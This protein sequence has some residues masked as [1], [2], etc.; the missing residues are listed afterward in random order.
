MALTA[1]LA[2]CRKYPE[3]GDHCGAKARITGT[4][5]VQQL[6]ISGIDSTDYYWVANCPSKVLFFKRSKF[7]GD[8][9]GGGWDL[10]AKKSVIVFAIDHDYGGS[11]GPFLHFGSPSSSSE[12]FEWTISKLTKEQMRL[13][14]TYNN[15]QCIHILK[16]L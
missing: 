12:S 15:M 13:E 4:W 16:R 10:D 5:E 9:A 6:T 11:L 8:C 3:G 2:A 1:S 7:R 14:A